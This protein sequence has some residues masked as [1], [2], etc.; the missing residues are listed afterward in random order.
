M[1]GADPPE[2]V[3]KADYEGPSRNLSRGRREG[4]GFFRLRALLGG[5]MWPRIWQTA[6][7]GRRL[8]KK[9]PRSFCVAWACLSR[10][11]I[12]SA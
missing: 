8:V 9:R 6:R 12:D 10:Q 5:T 1:A 3:L 11:S 4:F 7:L 2:G